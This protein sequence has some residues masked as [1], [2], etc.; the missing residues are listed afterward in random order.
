VPANFSAGQGKKHSSKHR[1][2]EKDPR[3]VDWIFSWRSS[4]HCVPHTNTR[5]DKTTQATLANDKEMSIHLR[6]LHIDQFDALRS[7]SESIE[8]DA[9][10]CRPL[11][12]SSSCSMYSP[13]CFSLCINKW[14]RD[15]AFCFRRGGE[16]YLKLFHELTICLLFCFTESLKQ[17]SLRFRTPAT[18]SKFSTRNLCNLREWVTGIHFL[19]WM[20]NFYMHIRLSFQCSY[21]L[22]VPH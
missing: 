2:Q 22:L 4:S 20:F 1:F 16:I 13:L 3:W 11:R 9:G 8:T 6:H 21:F 17:Q 19:R 10:T 7:L 15:P 18:H 5:S 14:T 12:V